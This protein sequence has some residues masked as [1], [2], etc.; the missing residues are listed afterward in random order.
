MNKLWMLL[1]SLLGFAGCD[2]TQEDMYGTPYAEYTVKG[3][4]TDAAGTPIAGIRLVPDKLI[5]AA[6]AELEEELYGK[7]ASYATDAQGNY[8]L[9]S[10]S[11]PN[12]RATALRIVA[13]DI[14]GES[15]GGRFARRWVSVPF[16]KTHIVGDDG[17]TV[18][19]S[20]DAP[21]ITLEKEVDR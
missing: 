17:W 9:H 21:I 15:N 6:G 10:E 16:D 14:D 8:I 5:S 4:V 20:I 1:L 3:R 12:G 13:E 2:E 18:T 19:Y 7:T 11:F